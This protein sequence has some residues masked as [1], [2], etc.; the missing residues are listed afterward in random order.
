MK[1]RVEKSNIITF[2]KNLKN[3]RRPIICTTEQHL[4]NYAPHQKILPG[5]DSYANIVNSNKEKVCIIGD[6]HLKRIKK[7]K[8]KCNVGQMIFKCFSGAD[9]KQTTT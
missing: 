7:R 4:Q 9:T 2:G 3:N 8:L 5:K 1:P 6:S